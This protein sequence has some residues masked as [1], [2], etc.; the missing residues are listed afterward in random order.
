M[1]RVKEGKGKEGRKEKENEIIKCGNAF[2]SL[3]RVKEGKKE[4]REE[5]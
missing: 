2:K 4:N 1:R 5:A 3:R